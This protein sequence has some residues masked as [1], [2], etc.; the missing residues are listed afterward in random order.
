MR[1]NFNN[2]FNEKHALKVF[3][4]GESKKQTL[5]D[6]NNKV[7]VSLNLPKTQTLSDVFFKKK[8]AS[9]LNPAI[10]WNLV[11][12]FIC[13]NKTSYLQKPATSINRVTSFFYQKKKIRRKESILLYRQGF[14]ERISVEPVRRSLRGFRKLLISNSSLSAKLYYLNFHSHTNFIFHKPKIYSLGSTFYKFFDRKQKQSKQRI[15]SKLK[16][17]SDS[18]DLYLP[19]LRRLF[20]NVKDIET[21]GKKNILA[22]TSNLI[23]NQK[24]YDEKKNFQKQLLTNYFNLNETIKKKIKKAVKA[25][26]RKLIKSKLF[27]SRSEQLN[28]RVLGNVYTESKHFKKLYKGK[29]QSSI[30][31]DS[32]FKQESFE[33]VEHQFAGD[34]IKAS[35]KKSKIT[36][37]S[38]IKFKLP[39]NFG[40]KVD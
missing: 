34:S 25:T 15:F 1:F 22:F 31:N 37:K 7:L 40:I 14:K 12:R 28:E 30:Q 3:Y 10:T 18:N 26:S 2:L 36:K 20:K 32:E 27:K 24:V 6:L 4:K 19:V 33:N 5:L 11:S 8:P 23:L 39:V 21:F 16:I 35:S 17:L 13:N 9:K 29:S 38:F